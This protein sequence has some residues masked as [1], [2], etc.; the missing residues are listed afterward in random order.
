MKYVVITRLLYIQVFFRN[1][2]QVGYARA[3]HLGA[4]KRFYYHQQSLEYVNTKLREISNIGHGQIEGKSIEQSRIDSGLK[5]SISG[6]A[7]RI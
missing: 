3:R 4:D 1:N 6:G 2:G 7:S 5:A